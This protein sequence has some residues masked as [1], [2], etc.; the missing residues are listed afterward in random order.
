MGA[1]RRL[2]LDKE[3]EH[4]AYLCKNERAFS[5]NFGETHSYLVVVSV[6]YK[7][8]QVLLAVFG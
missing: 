2:L 1:I 5:T 6:R 7:Y 8:L 4:F 3:R